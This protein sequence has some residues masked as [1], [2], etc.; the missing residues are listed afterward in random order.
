MDKEWVEVKIITKSEAI[1]PVSGIFYGLDVK[2]VAIED[3]NDILTREQGPLTW[4][5]ADLNIL[6]YG[7]KA[8][9]VKGYFDKESLKDDIDQYI[10]NKLNEIKE[11]GIDIGEGK[12]IIDSVNEEDWANNWKKYYKP[13]RIGKRIVVKP[14]WEEYK[15]EGNDI[16]IELDPGMAFGTGTHETTRMCVQALEKYIKHQDM[17]FDVGTGSGI[18]AIAAAKLGSKEVMAVDLDPVA[19]DSAM[20]NISF[21]D[22]SN[23]KVM[24]GNL[25]DVVNGKADIVVANIIAEI[26]ILLTDDVKKS[27]NQGGLFISSG[28]IRERQE[29]VMQK[30]IQSGFEI[31]EIN[32]DG[33]WVCI[34]SK[35]KGES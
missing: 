13:T 7:G 33:E 17:I 8:A 15:K 23:I 2:G 29:A 12:V 35:L 22:I 10:K 16:V 24:Q 3:P 21:N 6:E 19:V 9:V 31:M 4:D 28:I 26:I 11:M 34:V 25:L 20:Q 30:L 27:L 32:T 5:F 18:L 1:E 14:I